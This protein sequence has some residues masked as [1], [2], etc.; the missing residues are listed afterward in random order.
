MAQSTI[1]KVTLTPSFELS[2]EHSSSSYGQP[3]LVERPVGAAYGPDDMLKPYASW[4]IMP[5]REAVKRMAKTKEL[6]I[7]ERLFVDAFVN[8]G[9]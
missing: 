4:G 8:F 7:D 1:S 9:R 6:S 2:T 3:V 5:A